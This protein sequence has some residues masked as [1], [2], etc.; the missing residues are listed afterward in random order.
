MSYPYLIF[1]NKWDITHF[2]FFHSYHWE[3]LYEPV[4]VQLSSPMLVMSF[5]NQYFTNYKAKCCYEISNPI[6]S[7]F[8]HH[9]CIWLKEL[10][11]NLVPHPYL[12][13]RN[14]WDSKH[15]LFFLTFSSP[16]L[17]IIIL[18]LILYKLLLWDF[19]PYK[20]PILTSQFHPAWRATPKIWCHTPISS[21]EI[22]EIVKHFLFFLTFSSPTGQFCS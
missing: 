15:F 8:W 7:Q 17:V 21:L 19:Q 20:L 18:Q 3:I 22:S 1:R 12:I 9:S 5:C 2:L 6:N 16:M 14:K 10:S 11:P 4:G 13:F